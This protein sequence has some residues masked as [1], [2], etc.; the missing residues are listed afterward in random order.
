MQ[1][2]IP[3]VVALGTDPLNIVRSHSGV[4]LSAMIKFISKDQAYQTIQP[5]IKDLIKD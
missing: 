3:Q 5:L 1:V 2:L 4:V